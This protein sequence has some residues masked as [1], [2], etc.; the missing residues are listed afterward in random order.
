MSDHSAFYRQ[1][2]LSPPS[3]WCE[4][5]EADEDRDEYIARDSEYLEWLYEV[6]EGEVEEEDA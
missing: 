2:F 6:F 3:H 4:R 5:S 1:P